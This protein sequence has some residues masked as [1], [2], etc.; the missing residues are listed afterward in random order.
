MSKTND[1]SIRK[2]STT[3]ERDFPNL[4]IKNML[5]IGT[6]NPLNECCFIQDIQE[7]CLDKQKVKEAIDKVFDMSD[8]EDAVHNLMI[9]NELGL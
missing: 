1:G 8:E 4:K 2:E 6:Y 9:K 7:H 3:F 5:E